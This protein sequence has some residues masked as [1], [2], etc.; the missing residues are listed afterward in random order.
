MVGTST[1]C[2]GLL[3]GT[4]KMGST[5]ICQ[6]RVVSRN[7]IYLRI[8]WSILWC[9]TLVMPFVWSD[10]RRSNAHPRVWRARSAS[11]K[12]PPACLMWRMAWRLWTQSLRVSGPVGMLRFL[13]VAICKMSVYSDVFRSLYCKQEVG[14]MCFKSLARRNTQV[15]L[16]S[17]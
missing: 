2:L 13:D 12:P 11:L 5:Q 8:E 7:R 1:H 16:R 4:L 14:I 17:M 9:K 15:L 10:L 6:P 3:E